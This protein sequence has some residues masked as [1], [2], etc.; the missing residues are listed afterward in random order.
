[1]RRESAAYIIG[2]IFKTNITWQCCVHF[3]KDLRKK[4]IK[5]YYYQRPSMRKFIEMMNT[6]NVK[7]LLFKVYI[8]SIN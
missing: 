4:Y 1:M 5:P 3:F 8:D 2:E 6:R 7:E